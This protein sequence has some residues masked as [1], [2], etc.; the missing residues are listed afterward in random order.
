MFIKILTTSAVWDEA[1]GA[2]L[3]LDG[4][5]WTGLLECPLPTRGVVISEGEGLEAGFEIF[6]YICGW[7]DAVSF[8]NDSV[9]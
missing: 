3:G 1:V 9:W 5:H 4:N 7:V 8:K 2:G 6:E